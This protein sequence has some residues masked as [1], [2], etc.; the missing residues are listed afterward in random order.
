MLVTGQTNTLPAH[1]EGNNLL[2]T[3]RHEDLAQLMPHL[4]IWEGGRDAILYEPGDHVAY[5]Y[6]PCGQS[7][8]SFLVPLPDGRAVETVLIGREGAVGGIVS[9]GRLPAYS[10]SVVQHPGRFLRLPVS[11]L[12]AA[13]RTSPRIADLF[14]RYAD[15]LLAQVFQSVACNAAHTLEQRAAKWLIA[16]EERTGE[17]SIPMT[18]EQLASMLGV[19]RSYLSRVIR[20]YRERGALRVTRGRIEIL[21]RGLLATGACRC[22]ALVRGHFEAVLQGVYPEEAP[23]RPRIAEAVG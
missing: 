12:E 16:A 15:C 18:Q 14:A 6:F 19:G 9:R 23:P 17:A 20:T 22:N 1:V 8:A 2:R 3:L 13:K 7:L 4:E 21:D 5:A 11:T 10:R